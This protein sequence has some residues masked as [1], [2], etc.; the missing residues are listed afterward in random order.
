MATNRTQRWFILVITAMVV[1][2]TLGSFLVMIL[3]THEN[4]DLAQR[5]QTAEAAYK[6]ENEAH[7]KLVSARDDKLSAKYYDTFKQYASQPA[8]YAIDSVSK[9]KQTDL[10]AGDGKTIDDSTKFAAYY[11]GWNPDGKVFDQ[12]IDEGKLKG[13]LAIDG[14]KETS[15]IDGWK[16]GLKG[17]KIGGV[18]LLEIPSDKAYGE[19]GQGN[20]IPPNT[21]L[22]F[23]IMAIPAPEEVPEPEALTK[24]YETYQQAMIEYY[25]RAQ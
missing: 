15:V 8:K 23:V 13:P 4:Q 16:E 3:S 9:L 17:M 10:A 18:R 14:L 5:Y 25:T 12:S 22:K 19:A 24:A 7:Q 6:K 2:G 1:V 20:D 21:P 11:I